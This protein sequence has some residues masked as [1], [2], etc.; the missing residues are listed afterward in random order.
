[1]A[2]TQNQTQQPAGTAH[3]RAEQ[4]TG[5]GA[6]GPGQTGGAGRNR[7]RGQTAD[8]TYAMLVANGGQG[9]P[10]GPGA[11]E[12]PGNVGDDGG[13]RLAMWIGEVGLAFAAAAAAVAKERDT[14]ALVIAAAVVWA[15]QQLVGN[16]DTLVA[17]ARKQLG[18]TSAAGLFAMVVG[19]YLGA[20]GAVE[21]AAAVAVELPRVR[22]HPQQPLRVRAAAPSPLGRGGAAAAAAEGAPAATRGAAPTSV[23][24]AAAAAVLAAPERLRRCFAAAAAVGCAR[25]GGCGAR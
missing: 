7:W 2:G 4:T 6:D 13:R 8:A 15:A 21:R 10:R 9:R 16:L 19:V 24:A 23:A 22:V 14:L 5:A 3:L 25:G 18:E 1:M 12:Q 11:G 20:H 17:M